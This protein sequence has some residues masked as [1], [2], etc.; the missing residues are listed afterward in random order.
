MKKQGVGDSAKMSGFN[1]KLQSESP[2]GFEQEW[3]Q[4][5]NL[6]STDKV[7]Q[8]G[9]RLEVGSWQESVAM[10]YMS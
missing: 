9:G 5:N 7:D 3:F 10:L 6:M 2:E 8:C 4:G 1:R